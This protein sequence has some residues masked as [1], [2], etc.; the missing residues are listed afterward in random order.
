MSQICHKTLQSRQIILRFLSSKLWRLN[1]VPVLLPWKTCQGRQTYFCNRRTCYLVGQPNPISSRATRC[2]STK[3][4]TQI[5]SGT[6]RDFLKV[7]YKCPFPVS[8]QAPRWGYLRLHWL[9]CQC[10]A[11]QSDM[12]DRIWRSRASPVP[13]PNH[14]SHSPYPWTPPFSQNPDHYVEEQLTS[15]C[16]HSISTQHWN[17][18]PTG[19]GQAL[20][21]PPSQVSGYA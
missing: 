4:A 20:A 14:T 15:S 3:T 17:T 5:F 1:L 16:S 19:T 8:V 9:F 13:P 21:G 18:A 12:E 2:S 6:A 10:W 7:G 11:L